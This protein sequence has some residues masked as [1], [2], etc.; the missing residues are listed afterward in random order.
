M[1][2]CQHRDFLSEAH[3]DGSAT[4]VARPLWALGP[5]AGRIRSQI[6]LAII[7][8]ASQYRADETTGQLPVRPGP[9]LP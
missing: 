4:R 2:T 8:R 3:Q 6:A 7:R 5:S 9:E 1:L